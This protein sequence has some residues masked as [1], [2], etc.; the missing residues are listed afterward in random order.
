MGLGY[1]LAGAGAETGAVAKPPRYEPARVVTASLTGRSESDSE[2]D[3][4]LGSDS[5]HLS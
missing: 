5:W 1:R 4:G 3:S 2:S